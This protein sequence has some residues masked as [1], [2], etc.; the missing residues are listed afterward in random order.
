MCDKTYNGYTNYETWLVSLWMDNEPYTQ[1]WLKELADDKGDIW[2]KASRLKDFVNKDCIDL[3]N[4]S[5]LMA[6]LV[7]AAMSAVNWQEIVE[8]HMEYSDDLRDA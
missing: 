2:R 8:T 1:I 3:Q 5:S 6:D 7:G 4:I